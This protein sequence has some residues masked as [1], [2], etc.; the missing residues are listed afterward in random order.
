MR[1]NPREFAVLSE[2]V[3]PDVEKILAVRGAYTI[4]ENIGKAADV[5]EEAVPRPD[6]PTG[7]EAGGH[8]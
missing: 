7:S 8:G 6:A 4:V 2:H 1:R 3:Y 5:A